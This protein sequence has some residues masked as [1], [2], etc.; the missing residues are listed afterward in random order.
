[1]ETQNK[2]DKVLLP[3]RKRVYIVKSKRPGGQ[4]ET[5]TTK[6]HRFYHF[7]NFSHH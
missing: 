7:V 4:N 3:I 6:K 5:Y 1:M 2:I